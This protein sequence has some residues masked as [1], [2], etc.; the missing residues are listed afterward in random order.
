VVE[1]MEWWFSDITITKGEFIVAIAVMALLGS[2]AI[3]FE[4]LWIKS[5]KKK[6]K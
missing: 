5:E 2:V 3:F 4:V 6:S 1:M